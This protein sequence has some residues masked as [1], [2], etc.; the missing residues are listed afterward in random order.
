MD[1]FIFTQD[2]NRRAIVTAKWCNYADMALAELLTEIA[3]D[4]DYI[5]DVLR[6]VI[7]VAEGRREWC[8]Y[9]NDG[10]CIY[11]NIRKPLCRVKT[12]L[13]WDACADM[14]LNLKNCY[15]FDDIYKII[16]E[17]NDFVEHHCAPQ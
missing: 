9:V 15:R 10:S 7:S 8:G 4:Q 17:L 5:R 16:F 6:E 11:F 12:R 1:G 3:S 14:F 13:Y 2:G